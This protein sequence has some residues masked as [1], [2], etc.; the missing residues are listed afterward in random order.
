MSLQRSRFILVTD[1]E[2]AFQSASKRH[3]HAILQADDTLRVRLA[4]FFAKATSRNTK[5]CLV[6]RKSSPLEDNA[7]VMAIIDDI[8]IT[9]D[10]EANCRTEAARAELQSHTA[11]FRSNS[12]GYV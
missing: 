1:A 10:L 9:G 5:D 7:I 2:A 3:C 8:T 6:S 12:D 11:S 4:L